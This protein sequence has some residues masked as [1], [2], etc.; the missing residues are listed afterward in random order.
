[1]DVLNPDPEFGLPLTEQEIRDTTTANWTGNSIYILV[2]WTKND[3]Q[4]ITYLLQNEKP[5]LDLKWVFYY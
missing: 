2:Q 4:S 1:M 3:I 5:L